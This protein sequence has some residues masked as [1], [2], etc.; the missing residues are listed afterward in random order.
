MQIGELNPNEDEDVF[1]LTIS[2]PSFGI[3]GVW[4]PFGAVRDAWLGKDMNGELR[5]GLLLSLRLLILHGGY[6]TT[7]AE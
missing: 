6:V 3:R 2:V 1:L 4:I 5:I 7:E